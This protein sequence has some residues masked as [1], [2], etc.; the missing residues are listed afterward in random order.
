[1]EFWSRARDE[2]RF[3]SLDELVARINKDKENAR[4]YFRRLDKI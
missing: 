4:R 3:A 2:R 1:V